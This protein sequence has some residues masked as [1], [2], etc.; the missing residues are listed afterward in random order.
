VETKSSVLA[1]K[2]DFVGKFGSINQA[3]KKWKT[4]LLKWM[5]IFWATEMVAQF[6]LM[7]L[8]IKK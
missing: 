2:E 6:I 7:W 3:I 4:D 1:T 8:I 5:F